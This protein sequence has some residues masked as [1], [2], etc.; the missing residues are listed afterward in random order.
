MESK[1]IDIKQV[2][3]ALAH[4]AAQAVGHTAADWQTLAASKSDTI[5]WAEEIGRCYGAALYGNRPAEEGALDRGDQEQG[6]AVWYER[7]VSG[8]PGDSFWAETALNGFVHASADLDNG[9]VL[10]ALGRVSDLFLSKAAATFPAERAIALFAA[11]RRS[12]DV[13]SAIMVDSYVSALVRGM[14]QIG[15][16]DRLLKRMRTVAIRKMIDEGR[17]SIPLMTWDDALSVGVQEI[18][19]Q[20]KR[21]IGLL[22]DLHHAKATGKG[23]ATLKTVL[24]ELVDYTHTHFAYEENLFETHGYPAKAEHEQA[25]VAL[26]AQ[27]VAFGE[28]FE[29]GKASLSADLFLFLR[30]WLNGHIRGSDR[31]YS[32]FLRERGV[33]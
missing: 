3:D 9:R 15:L 30:N 19:T 14:S 25:H 2:A 22:N 5:P 21:L 32:P 10:A 7:L 4:G 18:D 8:A 12:L 23:D 17:E 16:N 26:K 27:V 13:A 33:S 29:S 24:R 6:F 20:H 31:R 11:F 1:G 28:A